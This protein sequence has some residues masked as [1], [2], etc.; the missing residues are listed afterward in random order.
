MAEKTDKKTA[1]ETADK[2]A[3]EKKSVGTVVWDGVKR[4]LT[5]AKDIAAMRIKESAMKRKRENL[6]TKLGKTVYA[7]RHPSHGSNK[8][9]LEEEAAKLVKQITDLT[10][11]LSSV[12]LKIKMRKSGLD[13]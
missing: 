4:E 13:K 7:Q 5:E 11:E 10:A 1:S 2:P 12:R 8:N 6:Y 9:D 3:E